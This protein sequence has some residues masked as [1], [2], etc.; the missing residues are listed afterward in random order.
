MRNNFNGH[1]FTHL[2]KSAFDF[3]PQIISTTADDSGDIGCTPG[4]A[5]Y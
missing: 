5:G 4:F 2:S 3:V 1:L